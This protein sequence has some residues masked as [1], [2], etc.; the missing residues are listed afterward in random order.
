MLVFFV[1]GCKLVEGGLVRASA[2]SRRSVRLVAGLAC[3]EFDMCGGVCGAQ[4]YPYP[5]V[6]AVCECMLAWHAL[7]VVVRHKHRSRLVVAD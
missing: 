7:V 1:P 6:S 5:G 2:F 4:L 3:L